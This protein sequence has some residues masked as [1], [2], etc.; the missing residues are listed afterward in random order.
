MDCVSLYVNDYE[1]ICML[2]FLFKFFRKRRQYLKITYK[3]D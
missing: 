3:R 2:S 1:T